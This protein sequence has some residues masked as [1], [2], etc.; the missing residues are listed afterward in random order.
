[1]Q[2]GLSCFQDSPFA[3]LITTEAFWHLPNCDNQILSV[4]TSRVNQFSLSPQSVRRSAKGALIMYENDTIQTVNET[5]DRIF[6]SLNASD[7]A[8][9]VRFIRMVVA[10]QPEPDTAEHGLCSAAG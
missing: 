7:E 3:M 1:M 10:G 5:W 8:T 9:L 6:S 4:S 2:K